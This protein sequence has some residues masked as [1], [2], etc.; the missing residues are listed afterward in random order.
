MQ[1]EYYRPLKPV[2]AVRNKT[3]ELIN[4]LGA[5][6]LHG[7]LVGLYGSVFYCL[8]A[9]PDGSELYRVSQTLAES[10]I[11]Y[12]PGP[13]IGCCVVVCSIIGLAGGAL[14]HWFKK[15]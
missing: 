9:Y 7:S 15:G 14:Y 1:T 12:L 4:D 8:M 3:R 5:G 6:M 2:Y 13:F 11:F 10:N